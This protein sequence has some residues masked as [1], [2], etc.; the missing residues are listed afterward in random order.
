MRTLPFED[1]DLLAISFPFPVYRRSHQRITA[2]N[3]EADRALLNGL[4]RRGFRLTSGLTIP[5]G[6]SCTTAAAAG[7]I[8]MP[9]VPR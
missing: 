7:T 4:E 8:S 9:V 2:M 6:R 5:A 3:R 1:L